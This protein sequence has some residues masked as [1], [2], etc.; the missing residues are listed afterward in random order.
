MQHPESGGHVLLTFAIPTF[1]RLVCLK[2]LVDSLLEQMA[3]LN[4]SA[5][6]VELLVCNNGSTDGTAGYLDGLVDALGPVAGLRVVHHTQNLGPDANAITCFEQARGQYVWIFGDDDLPL[7]GVLALLVDSLERD[8]PDLVY[9]PAKWHTGELNAYLSER[10]RPGAM[11]RVDMM[12][13]AFEA[14]AYIT[15]ISSWVVNRLTYSNCVAPAN[16]ARYLGTSLPQLEWTLTL[17]A[18]GRKL[19]VA[20][21]EWVIAR[22][23]NS[24][25]YP[26]FTVFV[27]NFSSVVNDKLSATPGLA[28]FLCD[29]MLRSYL[30]G[31]VWSVRQD[32]AGRFAE[33]DAP[34]LK[35]AVRKTWPHDKSAVTLLEWI[36]QWP[37]PVARAAFI[38]SWLRCQAWLAWLRLTHRPAAFE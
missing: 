12:A 14:N 2:L 36:T 38:A 9:L 31:L 4:A 32:A 22:A 8:Q 13:L 27:I 21:P 24:G 1:N 15:F 20:P 26:V 37:K 19:L 11:R 7:P 5:I 35:A 29:F 23:S 33:L 16:P 6:R 3:A 25:G 30:P 18:C 28:R 10:P 17:L 34:T